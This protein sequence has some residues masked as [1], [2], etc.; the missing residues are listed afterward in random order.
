MPSPTNTKDAKLWRVSTYSQPGYS[1][2]GSPNPVLN[3]A[4]DDV[5]FPMAWHGGVLVLGRALGNHV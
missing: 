4:G 2:G 5:P 3:F 1:E